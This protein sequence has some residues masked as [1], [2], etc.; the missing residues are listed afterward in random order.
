MLFINQSKQWNYEK[1]HFLIDS[2]DFYIFFF[3]M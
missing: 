3:V 2:L 1:I